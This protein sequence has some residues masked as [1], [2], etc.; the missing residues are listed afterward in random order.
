MNYHRLDHHG[1]PCVNNC[2]SFKTA[3]IGALVFLALVKWS[4]L[5]CEINNNIYNELDKSYETLISCA[6]FTTS[7]SIILIYVVYKWP[8]K[9]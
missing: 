2:I 8:N 9:L 5:I 3:I 4:D 6:L 7:L 1:E